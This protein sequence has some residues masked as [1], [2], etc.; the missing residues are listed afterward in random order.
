[1]RRIQKIV[2]F[3]SIL[4]LSGCA[5]V[6][7]RYGYDLKNIPDS[8]VYFGCTIPVKKY[9]QYNKDEVEV[10]GSIKAGDT[11]V[12]FECG[13][14]YVLGIFRQ[15]ACALGADL[16]NITYERGIDI[17]S[18]CYRAKA[19]FLRFK[20]REKAKTIESDAAYS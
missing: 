14:G 9:F 1:M 11:G 13:E 4:L 2:L 19:D 8:K 16:V 18:S 3:F 6:I 10:L 20:D 12:S 15:E 5:S 7:T 17:W